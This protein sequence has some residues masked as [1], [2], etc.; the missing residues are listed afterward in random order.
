MLTRTSAI[1]TCLV[2]ADEILPLRHAI[3]R[4]G[5]P[6]E[7]A[8]YAEDDD[9]DTLHIAAYRDDKLVGCATLILR[10]LGDHPGWQLRGMASTPDAARQGVGTA[11]I[12]AAEES[13]R[14]R[15]PRA[16][17]WCNARLV[18]IDFYRKQGF[19]A[20][21]GTF[22]EPDVGPHVRMMKPAAGG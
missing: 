16:L 8:R 3:L 21:S 5:R 6:L 1:Q 13:L 9:P 7:S 2:R 12:R 20:V 4:P 19:A 10:A 14:S 17:L 11:V 15:E 18:A 22:L